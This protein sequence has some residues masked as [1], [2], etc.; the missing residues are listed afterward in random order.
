MV[1]GENNLTF[2]LSQP[3]ADR[4]LATIAI[5]RAF[6][7]RMYHH[8]LQAHRE[9]IQ[10]YGFSKGATPLAYIQ[11]TFKPHLTEHLKEFFFTHCVINFLY[12]QLYQHKLVVVGEPL[13]KDAI[14]KPTEGAYFSFELPTITLYDLKH[15]W[16]RLPFKCPERKNYKDLDRQV[17]TF[18][19]EEHERS[20]QSITSEIQIGDWVCFDLWLEDST[21][22]NPLFLDYKDTLWLKIGDEEA[23]RDAQQVL[24]NKKVGDIFTASNL[25]LQNYIS[26]MLDTHYTFGIHIKDR[27]PA[28]FFSLEQ[29]KRHFKL[30]TAKETHLKLIEV[31]SYRNDLSQRR[32]IIEAIFKVLLTHHPIMIPDYLIKRQQ[33]IVLDAVH[34]NPDYHVYK[35]QNDFK[36]KVRMLAEKQLKE[37]ILIDH[38]TYQENIQVTQDDIISYLNLMKRPRTKEF[39]YFDLPLTKIRSQ[40]T[41]LPMELLRQHCLREKTLNQVISYLTRK[42]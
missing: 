27:V 33:Y 14:I 10:T 7:E 17:T 13:L 9:D 25:F 36:Q 37:T 19:K 5:G 24:L 15:D 32:E 35:A 11:H 31:F 42:V 1:Y 30:K 23:D 26:T 6:V 4:S 41:P 39:V 22:P 18:L 20:Q 2:T 12:R 21:A 38:I 34:I 16:K 28:A 29:F 3:H 8:A 40:E